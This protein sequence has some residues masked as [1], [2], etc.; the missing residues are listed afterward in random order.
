M[1]LTQPRV[2]VT[3]PTV[4]LQGNPLG[5]GTLPIGVKLVVAGS[6]F[7]GAFEHELPLAPL[8]EEFEVTDYTLPAGIVE[9]SQALFTVHGTNPHGSTISPPAGITFVADAPPADLRM[10]PGVVR[11]EEG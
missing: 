6:W 10:A 2:F 9:G 1:S 7:N 5:P 4:D 8:G 3:L 11:L